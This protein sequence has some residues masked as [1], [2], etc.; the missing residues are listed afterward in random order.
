MEDDILSDIVGEQLIEVDF[1]LDYIQL[2][3]DGPYLTIFMFP[4]VEIG[5]VVIKP[6][7]PGYRDALCKRITKIVKAAT[8]VENEKIQIV[9]DDGSKF[10]ISLCPE[11][12]TTVEA[13]IF[14]NGPER[15]EV[16]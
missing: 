7:Q 6:G 4:R 2:G 9:F 5:E 1:V 11:D 13:A 3:F 10:T 8:A 15:W 16:W 12:Y 14:R